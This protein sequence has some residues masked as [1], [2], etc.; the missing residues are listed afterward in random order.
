ML[1]LSRLAAELG[2]LVKLP[3]VMGE[4]IIGIV[5]G[6]SVFGK[7]F[8]HLQ[9]QLFPLIGNVSLALDG[10]AKLSVVMLLFVAGLEVQMQV[11]IK[12]GRTAISTGFIG[13]VVPFAAGF[14]LCWYNQSLFNSAYGDP[15]LLS[16]FMGTALS[17]SA[18][19]VISRILLDMNIFKTKIGMVIIASAMFMD[20]IGWLMFSLIIGL[21]GKGQDTS[22]ILKN[23]AYI[24]VFG[25]FMLTVGKK[26]IDKSLYWIQRKF[27]WPGGVLSLSLG[28]CFACGAFTESI[29]MH[30]VLGAF[31]AGI[32]VG[33]SVKLKQKA[34][35]IIHQF[36]TNVFAPLFFVSIGLQMNFIENFN[37]PLVFLILSSAIVSKV[38]GAGIGA[39]ISGFTWREA[40]A[41]GFGLNARGAMEIILGTLALTAGLINEEIFVALVIMAIVTSLFSAPFIRLFVKNDS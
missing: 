31:I 1:I 15:F 21:M 8:P 25:A 35:E 19:P 24:L 33:D 27:S 17:I 32:A 38:L 9:Q 34:R 12:Q 26:I 7:F 16:L 41:V 11:V 20:L 30:A 28:L 37:A 36:V 3:V 14:A 22:I 29:G 4:I 6:P 40:A 2:R 13:L 5:L 10:I 39:K 23:T 18:L